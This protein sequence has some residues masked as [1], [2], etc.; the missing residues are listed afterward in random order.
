MPRVIPNLETREASLDDV[1][2]ALSSNAP[3]P[4]DEDGF[5]AFAPHLQALANNRIF[6]ADMVMKELAGECRHQQAISGY[7]PQVIAL[8]HGNG[9]MIRANC[10]PQ[11][12]HSL[13]V[14]NRPESFYYGVPHDHNFSFLTTG[15][16][17]PGYWSDHYEYDHQSVAGIAGEPVALQAT[18]RTRLEPGLTHLYRA[19]RDVHSQM[20]PDAFSISL[21]IIESSTTMPLR[22][23]YLF[24][25]EGSRIAGFVNP[26]PTASL[27]P[28][29]AHL[30]GAD[31][32]DLLHRFADSH[33]SDRIRY[34]AV[35]SLAGATADPAERTAI[36]ERALGNGSRL[37]RMHAAEVLRFDASRDNHKSSV[38]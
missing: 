26:V 36:F 25:V 22:D 3:D 11:A 18:D 29:L 17:G 1:V 33:P 28:L 4:R 21:N 32:R 9:L 34:A 24:D 16:A 30:D 19:H 20:P 6:L 8:Y 13:V 27:L 37:V 31:G 7:G 15:Y 5:A 2:E 35:Q 14:N 23:Q 10:W 38:I 12:L